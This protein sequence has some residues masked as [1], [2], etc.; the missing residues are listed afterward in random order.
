M[1]SIA[2]VIPFFG[3]KPDYYDVWKYSALKNP[4]I[5]FL[6]FTDVKEIN[7]E[8][9]IKVVKM[10][11]DD[12]AK[13]FKSKFD[14]EISLTSPYKLCDFKPTYGYVLQSYLSG[15]DFWGHAD[16]DVI[17]GDISSF[18][19]SEILDCN[20]KILELGH[21][22]L[23]RNNDYINTAF[24]KCSGYKD[25]DYKKCLSSPDAM[26]FDEFLGMRHVCEKLKVPTY[27]N[28]KIFFDVLSYKK[29]F[30][31][32]NDAFKESIFRYDEKDGKLY[33]LFN[34]GEE[35]KEKEIMYAHFQ[36]RKMDYS[37]FKEGKDFYVVPNK[38]ILCE[39]VKK[40]NN[41]F[42]IKGKTLYSLQRKLLHVKDFFARYKKSGVKSFKKFRKMRKEFR[43]DL[44]NAK[45]EVN[46]D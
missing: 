33:A 16:V 44:A 3:K 24:L 41:L 40:V 4:C 18:I 34:E 43:L 23:Y 37:H 39:Q 36:K 27:K 46:N 19:T 35:I 10:T 38:L 14:F 6:F 22:C 7:E 26:Y 45:K 21:F 8:K 31:H 9:N 42:N 2:V 32:I 1:K 12:F 25:Y 5:D 30:S 28:D 20:D 29:Q 13:L 17:L 11:F 15:Y